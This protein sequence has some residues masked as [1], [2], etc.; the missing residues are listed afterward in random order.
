MAKDN[1]SGG[2]GGLDSL[3]DNEVLGESDVSNAL[4]EMF[5]DNLQEETENWLIDQKADLTHTQIRAFAVA[6][7]LNR[8]DL[9]SGLSDLTHDIKHLSVSLNRKG[10]AEMVEVAK[11]ISSKG[12]GGFLRRMFGGGEK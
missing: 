3:L 8:K 9:F 11:G 10:R 5:R 4:K 6:S 2:G 1:S 12:K 7:F